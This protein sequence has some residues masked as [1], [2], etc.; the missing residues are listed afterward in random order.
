[1]A[2]IG[3]DR[4][5]VPE[6]LTSELYCRNSWGLFWPTLF[7]LKRFQGKSVYYLG[8]KDSEGRQHIIASDQIRAMTVEDATLELTIITDIATVG[9]L[10]VRVGSRVEFVRWVAAMHDKWVADAA[11]VEQ[12][13]LVAPSR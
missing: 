10:I 3:G 13:K 9:S 2:S 6:E 5:G 8:Y 1:M 11:E 4:G 7:A 12:G